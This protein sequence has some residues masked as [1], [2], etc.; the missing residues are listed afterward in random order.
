MNT[1]SD[2]PPQGRTPGQLPLASAKGCG[3]HQT[4]GA[5][6]RSGRRPQ[7]HPRRT[8][9]TLLTVSAGQGLVKRATGGAPRAVLA[10]SG[11]AA[12]FQDAQSRPASFGL[13]VS[14][15]RVAMLRAFRRRE[16]CFCPGI[17][18]EAPP[19]EV[20]AKK[21]AQIIIQ[22]VD[23]RF[24]SEHDHFG[25]LRHRLS[26]PCAH[27]TRPCRARTAARRGPRR[28]VFLHGGGTGTLRRPEVRRS[29]GGLG[30]RRCLRKWCEPG[31]SG[32]APLIFCIFDEFVPLSL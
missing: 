30:R 32:S 3:P 5:F 11:S 8:P 31:A 2:G 16:P 20:H 15:R 12:G 26:V 14:G 24:I 21:L 17:R 10:G 9:A 18:A 25:I 27:Q 29:A 22:R 7:G 1:I 19:G 6:R 28:P 4:S 23:T 13:F